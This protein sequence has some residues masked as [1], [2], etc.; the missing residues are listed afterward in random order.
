MLI[1]QPM[2]FFLD[3]VDEYKVLNYFGAQLAW[4]GWISGIG[5]YYNMLDVQMEALN[6]VS[7][8]M[9]AQY[10]ELGL[11][12]WNPLAEKNIWFVPRTYEE[13]GEHNKKA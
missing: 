8:L 13:L 12:V 1:I 6:I 10:Y 5:S 9:A 2:S 4:G 11:Q 7:G 3:S